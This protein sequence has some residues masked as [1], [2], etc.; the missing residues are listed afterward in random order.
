MPDRVT[1]RVAHVAAVE[2]G[3]AGL[4]KLAGVNN[5]Y[6]RDD[7]LLD[8]RWERDWSVVATAVLDALTT[9][10]GREVQLD[11]ADG[12]RWSLR[13]GQKWRVWRRPLTALV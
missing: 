6:S 10:A 1:C 12:A 4:A 11:F 5:D 2:A 9:F 13:S 3:A 8:L 7:L